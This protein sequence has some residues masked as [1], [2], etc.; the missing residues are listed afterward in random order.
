MGIVT[1]SVIGG[2]LGLF[3]LMGIRIVDQTEL[4]LHQRFGK[5]VGLRKP[6]IR[7]V[8]PVIDSMIK[9]NMTERLVD[10]QPQKVISADDLNAT[11][12]GVV[13]YKVLSPEKAIYK[14]DDYQV[15]IAS[16]A[17]TT[18]RNIIGKMTLT[19]ANSKRGELNNRLEK[20]LEKQIKEWGVDIVRVEIQRIEPPEDVQE[21]MNKVV[22]AEREKIAAVEIANAAEKIADGERRSTI[23]TAEGR[24]RSLI[25]EAEGRAESITKVA[26]ARAKEIEVVNKSLQE[27]FIGNAITHKGY[28]TAENSLKAGTKYV[29]DS[30]SKIM[31]VISDSAGVPIP[32]TK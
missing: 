9:V 21:S 14:V 27:H 19:E 29:I 12:D 11:V 22:K 23:K 18:L 30:K 28:E 24:K 25:L 7:F 16:L 5:H 31:N 2:L 13:Y 32:V 4:G 6:G 26:V 8:I 20:E 17:R 10:T 3:V 1:V 15:Q